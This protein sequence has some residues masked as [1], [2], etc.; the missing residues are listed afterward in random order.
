[1]QLLLAGELGL[2][3]HL[4]EMEKRPAF[5]RNES[6]RAFDTVAIHRWKCS[7]GQKQYSVRVGAMNAG[8]RIDF[9]GI[10]GNPSGL[11]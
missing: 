11:I 9:C 1:M 7:G 10:I 5:A 3:I 6:S 8:C 2:N 4:D